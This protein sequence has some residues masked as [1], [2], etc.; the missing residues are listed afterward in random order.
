MAQN[1]SQDP[2]QRAKN[3]FYKVATEK[4]PGENFTVY[5][6]MS[7]AVPPEESFRWLAWEGPPHIDLHYEKSVIER[8]YPALFK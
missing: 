4:Y 7:S 5:F 6:C 1:N 3:D 8:K 2:L